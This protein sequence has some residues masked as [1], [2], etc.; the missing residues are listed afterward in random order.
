MA[1]YTKAVCR[2][3][4]REGQKL[5]LK[6]DRCNGPKCSLDKK[7][8][9]PGMH[10]GGRTRGR[11]PSDYAMQLREKQKLRTIYGV[12]ERQFR[13]YVA[14]AVKSK[15]VSG[16]M[17]LQLLERRL[18]SVVRRAGL[19]ASQAQA[20]QLVLHRHF[21]INGKPVNIPSM[22]LDEG[23]VIQ[24]R[25]KSHDLTPIVASIGRGAYGPGWMEVDSNARRVTI[26]RLPEP[27][28]IAVEV[29]EQQVIEFYAR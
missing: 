22:L 10:G 9:P 25:E 13:R 18:D 24:V 20:R 3:C 1:R 19:A 2:L 14:R 15:G 4:R 16:F 28:D 7:A 12:L 21:T 8:Y 29:D 23:D 11:R 17:L 6:G 27:D 26:S 5:F